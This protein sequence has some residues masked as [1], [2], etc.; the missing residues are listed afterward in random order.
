MHQKKFFS[1][2]KTLVSKSVNMIALYILKRVLFLRQ[3]DNVSAIFLLKRSYINLENSL[4]RKGDDSTCECY[5]I[6]VNINAD[7]IKLEN[8]VV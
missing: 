4:S 7:N 3:H 8:F 1:K 2:P 6:D 5:F